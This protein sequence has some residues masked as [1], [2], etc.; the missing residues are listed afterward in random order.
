MKRDDLN[1]DMIDSSETSDH[2]M[3]IEGL[4][5]TESIKNKNTIRIPS[6]DVLYQDLMN[7]QRDYLPGKTKIFGNSQQPQDN[8]R[9][10]DSYFRNGY[11]AERAQRAQY[12][13]H[14][15]NVKQPIS[16]EKTNEYY[17]PD[18]SQQFPQYKFSDPKRKIEYASGYNTRRKPKV[19]I[20]SNCETRTTPSWRRSAD[21]KKLLCNACGLYQKLHGRSRPFAVNSDGKTKAIKANSDRITCMNC[22]TT[23][24]S[25]WRR[26]VD[27]HV[28]CNSCGLYLRDYIELQPEIRKAPYDYRQ[29]HDQE[30]HRNYAP[31]YH[32]NLQERFNNERFLPQYSRETFDCDRNRRAAPPRNYYEDNPHDAKYRHR[33]RYND[34]SDEEDVVRDPKNKDDESEDD[35]DIKNDL[36]EDD[37][38]CN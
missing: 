25:Y 15:D 20:C 38:G 29:S 31:Q 18:Y 9:E 10:Y 34:P 30:M 23:E 37:S 21:G 16:P 1:N 27:G 5:T 6:R 11:E 35:D 8:S 24:S 7:R 14:Y 12:P 26:S 17:H 13:G 22:R 2:K 28:L 33:V 3:R 19:R 36:K 4:N 32:N